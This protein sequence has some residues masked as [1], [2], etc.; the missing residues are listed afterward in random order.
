MEL[1]TDLQAIRKEIGLR[2]EEWINGGLE[3]GKDG[4]MDSILPIFQYS[5]EDSRG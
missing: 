3:E 1:I 2:L 4:R 5:G